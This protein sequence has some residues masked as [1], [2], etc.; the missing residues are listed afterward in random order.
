MRLTLAEQLAEQLGF[1]SEQLGLNSTAVWVRVL[2]FFHD[3]QST[4]ISG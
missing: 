1:I 4:T 3:T 2:G